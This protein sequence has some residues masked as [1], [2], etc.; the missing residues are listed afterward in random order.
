M[1]IL[2]DFPPTAQQRPRVT[3]QHTYDPSMRD[4]VEFLKSI[5]DQLPATPLTEALVLRI[6][7]SFA[8][9]KSHF[10]RDGTLLRMAPARHTKKPDVDNLIKFVMDALNGHLYVDDAQ[11]VSVAARKLYAA[12]DGIE[13]QCDGIAEYSMEQKFALNHIASIIGLQDPGCK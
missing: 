11:V 1:I 13:I 12:E 9:P 7:F 5:M 4:K 8:R 2:S 3:R 6:T 10:K